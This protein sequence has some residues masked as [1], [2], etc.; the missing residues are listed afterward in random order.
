MAT[1][2]DVLEGRHRWL[3]PFNLLLQPP[4]LFPK[5]LLPRVNGNKVDRQDDPDGSVSGK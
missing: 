5:L 4:D 1:A 3:S 2:I